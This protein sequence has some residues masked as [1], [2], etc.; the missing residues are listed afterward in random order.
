MQRS[1]DA[2]EQEIMLVEENMLD[3]SSMKCASFA[4]LEVPASFSCKSHHFLLSDH[5]GPEPVEP[6]NENLC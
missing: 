4:G 1:Q 6:Q 3:P 2:T 5:D